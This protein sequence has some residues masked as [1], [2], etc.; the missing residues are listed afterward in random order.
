MRRLLVGGLA[1]LTGAALVFGALA[2]VPMAA[3]AL[4]KKQCKAVSSIGSD[5][6]GQGAS[7]SLQASKLKAV[8]SSFSKASKKA[9]GKLKSALKTLSSLYNTAGSKG[10]PTDVVRY[11]VSTSAS[12]RYT[13]ALKTVITAISSCATSSL[14][15]STTG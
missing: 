7:N 6:R 12:K 4:N 8:G 15:T 1:V 3:G 14:P 2:V 13:N 9:S 10:S 11:F 5:I